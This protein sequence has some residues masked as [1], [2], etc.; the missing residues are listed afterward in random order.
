MVRHVLLWSFLAGLATSQLSPCADIPDVT[1]FN[2]PKLVDPFTFLNGSTVATKDDWACRQEEIKAIF[3]RYELGPK[4]EPEEVTA[5]FTNNA[6]SITVQSE[7]KSI[8]FSASI[9]FPSGN[10]PFPALIA[11]GG[12]S[13]PV[14][15]GV[16]VIT[17][18]NEDIAVTNPRGR[19][20]FYDLYGS[21]HQA[22]GL[23]AW[24][25]GVSRIVDAL[26]QL[27][28]TTTKINPERV[29]VTGC[30]RNGKG[31]MMS[32]A[33][34][35]RIRL[36]IPQEAGSGGISV[37]RIAAEMKQNG[38]DVEDAAQVVTGDGWFAT[39]F[40]KYV[41]DIATL[42]EDH[43]LLA[44]LVAPRSLLVVENSGIDYLAPIGSFGGATA[45]KMIYGALGAADSIGFSQ[46]AHGTSHCSMPSSQNPDVA[47]YF[48]RFLLDQEADTDIF[49]TDRDFDFD[50]ARWI[51]WTA[52][53]LS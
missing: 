2:N 46:V 15:S 9:R 14:P 19:G 22:G 25:W 1:D 51:D 39:E 49:K 43:H 36:T 52:P 50:N 34:D 13:I 29:A 30:S 5:S 38:T 27:G 16:A 3:H 20:K 24:A 21:D 45:A 18:N 6:L 47:A 42:P 12:A 37:W 53:E 48:N 33:F 40:E 4:P 28:A 31:A 10:G 8:S 44:G 11:L 26:E 7:G 23:I 41:D 32:G 35:T 17:Y